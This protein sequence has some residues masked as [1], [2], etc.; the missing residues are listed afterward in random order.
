M[1]G[2]L[3]FFSILLGMEFVLIVMMQFIFIE[4]EGDKVAMLVFQ[5]M[6]ILVSII[7][8]GLLHSRFFAGQQPDPAPVC[9]A[10]EPGVSEGD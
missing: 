4:D 2:L 1:D 8:G 9:G 6:M 5:L 10:A 7:F 3:V